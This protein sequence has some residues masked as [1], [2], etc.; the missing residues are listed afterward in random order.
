VKRQLA[1]KECDSPLRIR[2]LFE[3]TGQEDGDTQAATQKAE[4]NARRKEE[5]D[6]EG[7][8]F[9][10]DQDAAAGAAGRSSESCYASKK[11]NRCVVC[12]VARNF[13]RYHAVPT[14]YRCHFP[15]QYR[16]NGSHDVILL[17]VTC[18]EEASKHVFQ[19]KQQ[20]ADEY[21]APL[22]WSNEEHRKQSARACAARRAAAALLRSGDSM[23]LDRI[24]ELKSKLLEWRDHL[25]S[26]REAGSDSAIPADIQEGLDALS[27][28]IRKV[29][30]EEEPTVSG[31]VIAAAHE[32]GKAGRYRTGEGS[33]SDGSR[34]GTVD[35]KGKSMRYDHGKVVAERVDD[36]GALIRRFRAHFVETMKPRFLPSNWCVQHKVSRSFGRFSRYHPDNQLPKTETERGESEEKQGGAKA[37]LLLAT[38]Q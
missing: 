26:E 11:E 4:R 1:R 30:F 8:L 21:Q 19:L 35:N 28:G 24:L 9:S 22:N 38:L 5:R 27:S 12:G 6:G 2:L 20:L 17:C 31:E 14:C 16:C 33:D 37:T 34:D 36:I 7:S 10:D 32:A 13:L 15:P 3:P 23:P 25:H 18:H 29:L